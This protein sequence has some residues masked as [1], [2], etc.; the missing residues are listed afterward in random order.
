MV[1]ASLSRP[2]EESQAS[3]GNRRPSASLQPSREP[4][5]ESG[6]VMK[7]LMGAA[8]LEPSREATGASRTSRQLS[9][10]LPSREATQEKGRTS[11]QLSNP[12][13]GL[14]PSRGPSQLSKQLAAQYESSETTRHFGTVEEGE[15]GLRSAQAGKVD[16]GMLRASING[17]KAAGV[18]D[19]HISAAEKKLDDTTRKEAE[20]A[21][22]DAMPW[23]GRVDTDQLFSSIQRASVSHVDPALLAARCEPRS[24]ACSSSLSLSDHRRPLLLSHPGR[25]KEAGRHRAR[26]GGGGAQGRAAV[27]RQGGRGEALYRDHARARGAR[28]ELRARLVTAELCEPI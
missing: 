23:F 16:T 11:R 10:P 9:N 18:G 3:G 8:L 5:Q 13:A 1:R 28:L 25:R 7:D 4:T 20:A 2:P 6:G 17:A 15:A 26:G 12:L 27:V 19:S 22:K 21:L 24:R 14:M